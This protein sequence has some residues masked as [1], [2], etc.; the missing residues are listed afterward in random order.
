M[1]GSSP[2][3]KMLLDQSGLNPHAGMERE[4]E[5]FLKATSK[6]IAENETRKSSTDVDWNAAMLA[7]T[8]AERRFPLKYFEPE[9][10]EEIKHS[11]VTYNVAKV[12]NRSFSMKKLVDLG[13]DLSVW[14]AKGW[15]G[16]AFKVDFERDVAPRVRLLADI[17]H[18]GENCVCCCLR[19]LFQF[20]DALSDDIAFVLT[21]NAPILCEDL[22]KL[23]TRVSYLL[24]KK[25]TWTMVRKILTENPYWLT[26]TVEEIDA[27]LG[28]F[29]KSFSLTGDQVRLLASRF[30]LIVTWGGVPG[31]I[32]INHFALKELCGFTNKE[33][34]TMLLKHP[35]LYYQQDDGGLRAVFDMLHNEVGFSHEMIRKFPETL[36]ADQFKVRPRHLFL[37][38]IGRAQY[39]PKQ[40]RY[41]SPV[42]LAT[43]DE[44]EFSTKVAK[45]PIEVYN[46]FLKTV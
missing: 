19:L 22:T 25:F 17:I 28:Y 23:K 9:E 26:Y 42:A 11:T 45:V 37:K 13:V 43:S 40:P 21:K 44:K 32:R 38:K 46:E 41:V 31:Q 36:C 33:L 8:E 5:R 35:E 18:S 20:F 16:L 24:S 3:F 10:L 27:R 2:T 15:T 12:I 34:K 39:D 4:A 29:Q 6:R 7:V 14:E 30:P 1:V